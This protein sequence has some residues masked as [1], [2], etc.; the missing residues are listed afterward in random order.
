MANLVLIEEAVLVTSKQSRPLSLRLMLNNAA[1]LHWPLNLNMS[2]LLHL[3]FCIVCIDWFRGT[4]C[5]IGRRSTLW[6]KLQHEMFIFRWSRIWP[7]GQFMSLHG[8]HSCAR[9]L[10]LWDELCPSSITSCTRVDSVTAGHSW[11][12]LLDWLWFRMFSIVAMASSQLPR[13]HPIVTDIFVFICWVHRFAFTYL[14]AIKCEAVD[15][16][17]N[18]GSTRHDSAPIAN[19]KDNDNFGVLTKVRL[20]RRVPRPA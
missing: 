8:S 7:V 13:V 9:W 3:S 6:G 19:S 18:S 14:L 16:D 4:P 1:S 12:A 2:V 17:S 20:V 15:V 11:N 10:I 5:V